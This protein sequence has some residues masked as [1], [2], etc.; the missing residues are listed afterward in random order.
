MAGGTAIMAS[1]Y[2]NAERLI[3]DRIYRLKDVQSIILNPE[4]SKSAR[5]GALREKQQ[6]KAEIDELINSHIYS[7]TG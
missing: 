1:E 4:T 6:L 7:D 5:H 2:P 3:L